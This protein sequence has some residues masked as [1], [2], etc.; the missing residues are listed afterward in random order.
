LGQI[1]LFIQKKHKISEEEEEEEGDAITT[2][3]DC[4]SYLL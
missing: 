2:M 4:F 3:G 1:F